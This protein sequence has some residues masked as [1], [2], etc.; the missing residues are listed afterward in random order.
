MCIRDR[1][2]SDPRHVYLACGTYTNP[3]TPNVSIL[4]SDDSGHTFQRTDVPFKFGG[5]EDGR[6]NG[7]RLVVDPHDGRILYLGTRHD[8][9]WRSQDY[10]C[11]LY[12][13][14]CV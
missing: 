8:G 7:E 3:S 2:P 4:R 13:S 11:L 14:R 10:G 9:L 5:N 12:T 6:G 1:D